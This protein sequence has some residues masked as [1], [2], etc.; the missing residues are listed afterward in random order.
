ML[1]RNQT[2][3]PAL[4]CAVFPKITVSYHGKVSVGVLLVSCVSV[5]IINSKF[6]CAS[7]GATSTSHLV[8][9]QI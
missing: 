6:V 9:R 1:S 8:S 5:I 7:P 2:V 4:N 3:F